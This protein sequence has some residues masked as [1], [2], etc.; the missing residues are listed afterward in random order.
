MRE[1]GGMGE[2][3]PSGW[4]GLALM[5]D[6][7]AAA[8]ILCDVFNAEMTASPTE[9]AH[10]GREGEVGTLLAFMQGPGV[11]LRCPACESVMLRVVRTPDAIYPDTRGAAYLCLR[12]E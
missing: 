3:D 5:L 4:P 9:C 1:N 10:C 7:N 6:A 11:I 12:R 2:M 8:G